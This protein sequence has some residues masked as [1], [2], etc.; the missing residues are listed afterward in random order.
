MIDHSSAKETYVREEIDDI[1]WLITTDNLAD[2]FTNTGISKDI[3]T[4]HG[5][6][7]A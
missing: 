3:G 5:N 7:L 1:G 2:V 4:I 6:W